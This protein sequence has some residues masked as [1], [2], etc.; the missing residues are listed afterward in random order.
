MLTWQE[1]G[2]V[3]QVIY[4]LAAGAGGG[5][6][7][8]YFLKIRDEKRNRSAVRSQLIALLSSAKAACGGSAQGS[9]ARTETDVAIAALCTRAISM[10]AALAL[11]PQE[12]L[13][14]QNAAVEA[15]RA[16]DTIRDI[17]ARPA[18]PPN[19]QFLEIA[20]PAKRLLD[21]AIAAIQKQA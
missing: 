8:A 20:N 19:R 6:A 5:F 18:P 17:L 10:D 15:K 1:I 3:V 21:T 2:P 9:G 12:M 4:T 14:V 11:S 16:S 7:A 13:L